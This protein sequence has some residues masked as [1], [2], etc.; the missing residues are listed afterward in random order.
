VTKLP[1]TAGTSFRDAAVQVWGRERVVGAYGDAKHT[2][3][4][5][6]E[7]WPN[8]FDYHEDR[9][10]SVSAEKIFTP[11][12]FQEKSDFAEKEWALGDPPSPEQLADL[13]K[14]LGSPLNNVALFCGHFSYEQMRPILKPERTF[15]F[16]R[17][18]IA[19]VI[20]AW[21]HQVMCLRES[22]RARGGRERG[23][24]W[25]GRGTKWGGKRACR[26][27]HVRASSHQVWHEFVRA[28]AYASACA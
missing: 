11:K 13:D 19:R 8:Q 20:S 1:K 21:S 24:G 4:R 7:I 12:F 17:E 27:V 15:T 18:P 26:C 23:R 28:C 6:R 2:H 10:L 5:V 3:S 9:I 22:E 16:V 25:Q 14:F